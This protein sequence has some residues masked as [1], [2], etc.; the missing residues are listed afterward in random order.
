VNA[1]RM[2]TVPVAIAIL[3]RRRCL[4][5]RSSH[6]RQHILGKRVH[7]PNFCGSFHHKSAV[8]SV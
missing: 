7:L 4:R 6:A 8:L 5:S 3:H 1:V 2:L